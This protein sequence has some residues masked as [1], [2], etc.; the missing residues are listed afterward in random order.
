ML[1]V[2]VVLV[3]CGGGDCGCGNDG[4]C[5][6]GGWFAVVSREAKKTHA[7]V[8]GILEVRTL[9][10]PFLLH[11]HPVLLTSLQHSYFRG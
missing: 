1:V 7:Q 5:F 6:G 8:D 9:P 2:V 11:P 4:V 3:V 10:S